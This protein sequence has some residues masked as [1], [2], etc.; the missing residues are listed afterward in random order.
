[1]HGYVDAVELELQTGEV[2]RIPDTRPIH[3]AVVALEGIYGLFTLQI[4][5][6]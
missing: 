1:M 5:I 4:K 3:V 6:G 2:A